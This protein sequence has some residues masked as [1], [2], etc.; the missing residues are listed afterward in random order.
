LGSTVVTAERAQQLAEIVSEALR[1]VGVRGI[2]QSGWAGLEATGDDILTIGDT[3]HEW[4]FPQMA[5]AAHHC[6]AGTTAAALRAG[7][8]SIA[9][10]GAAGDQPFWGRRL[11]TLGAAATPL[12]QRHL[13]AQRLADTIRTTLAIADLRNATRGLAS[14]IAGEGGTPAAV[15]AI[16]GLLYSSHR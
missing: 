12:P 16:E 3:P 13:T 4:L 7:I 10:P 8:P 5:A 6:G 1:Q 14:R 2:V 11:H 9:L 15:T